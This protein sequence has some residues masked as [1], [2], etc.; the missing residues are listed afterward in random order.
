VA[1]PA[2]VALLLDNTLLRIRV[3]DGKVTAKSS[4]GP[5]SDGLLPG[6]YI[7]LAD[8]R[9]LFVLALGNGAAAEV[10]VVDA[11]TLAVRSRYSLEDGVIYHGIVLS[12]SGVLYAYGNRRRELLDEASDS[13][14][15]DVVVTTVDTGSG[16]VLATTT[17]RRAAG[18]DWWVYS[19]AVSRDGTAL[20]LTYHG[21][22]TTGGDRFS[23]SA[24]GLRRCRARSRYAGCLT[25]VHGGVVAHADGFLAAT[26]TPDVLELDQAGEVVDSLKVN[27]GGHVMEIAA[28]GSDLYAVDSCDQGGG[29]G[30]I[31]LRTEA[32][33]T[34]TGTYVCGE[35][36]A[37]GPGGQVALA[38]N[39][40]ALPLAAPSRV[41]VLDASSGRVV[42]AVR[43]DVEVLDLAFVP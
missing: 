23:I 18:L 17:V 21:S 20:V 33:E 31:D 26:G 19:G 36:L 9:R 40:G 3:S 35:R 6:R 24:E 4:L 29:L 27:L 32:P 39:V 2:L 5:A 14:T 8:D 28:S 41:V 22:D 25:G 16:A 7:A 34:W 11:T 37:A 1:G 13:W 15:L 42:R 38:A 30:T 12:P 10:A 43:T